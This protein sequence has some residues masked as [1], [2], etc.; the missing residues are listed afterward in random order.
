MISAFGEASAL[1]MDNVG[2]QVPGILATYFLFAIVLTIPVSVIVLLRYRRA[3]ARGMRAAGDA[4]E[5]RRSTASDTVPHTP[6]AGAR[7]RQE[8]RQ[9]NVVRRRMAVIYSLA[10]GAAA[11]VLTAMILLAL[12]EPF[13]ALRAWTVWY[14]NAWP[15]LP[16]LAVLLAWPRPKALSVMACYVLAG[17]AIVLSVSYVSLLVFGQSHTTPFVKAKSFLILLAVQAWLPY[18]VILVT[19]GRR[20]RSVSPLVLAGLLVFSYSSLILLNLFVNALDNPSWQGTLLY[21]GSNSYHVWFML[22][23][24]PVGFAC[25][26]VLRWVGERY[27]GRAFSD[28]QLLVD[29]WWLIIIFAECASLASD[30]GWFALFGLSAFVV[31]RAVVALGFRLWP[32]DRSPPM[33]GRLLLLRVFGFQRRTE[34]LFDEI[35]QRWRL[36]GSVKMIAGADLAMRT[37]DPGDLIAFAG[38][39]IKQMFVQSVGDLGQR[40]GRLD[41][42]RDPDGRFRIG[43]FFCHEDTWRPTLAALAMRSDVVLMDL[44]G[45][46]KDNSGCLYELDQIVACGLLARTLFVIDDATDVQLLRSTLPQGVGDAALSSSGAPSQLN[47]ERA[48]SQSAAEL[49]RIYGTLRALA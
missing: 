11:A 22:A 23:A 39:R 2:N 32:V 16:V 5:D 18:L 49:N 42:T 30:F 21:F 15:L 25:W 9:E 4:T 12:G 14:V 20:L 36:A 1:G 40:L 35:G 26:R 28:V 45:F 38:G 7:G 37:I 27:E 43:E 34:R 44:R 41:E 8:A 46:S 47:L 19:G 10:G 48:R 17:V 31:Y 3:V 24:L 13:S 29:S 33:D 6:A